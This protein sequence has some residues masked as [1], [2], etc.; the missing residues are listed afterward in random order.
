MLD[1]KTE[2]LLVVAEKLNFTKAAIELNLTQPAVSNHISKLEESLGVSLF[3]RGKTG[4]KLT[5]DGEIVVK[6]AKR[7]KALYLKLQNEV[8]NSE[9]NLTNLRVGITHTSES[10]MT[11][12]ALAKYTQKNSHLTI[13]I[14]TDTIKNLYELLSNYEI[15]I[16]IVDGKVNEPSFHFLMIDTDYLLCVV[17]NTNH[18][19]KQTA[20]SLND[21]R[22]EKM[23]LRLPSSATRV[24]FEATLNS[25]NDSIDNYNIALEVD[26]IATI[27]DLV[28][29][30]LGVSILPK[31]A[32]LNEIK[33]GKLVA[34]AIENLS[35][36]RETMIV[37]NQDFTHF[38]ILQEITRTYQETIKN[39]H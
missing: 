27:K 7:M 19:A 26:N 35:M 28:R 16:A 18:L 5:N 10:N 9:K 31:S 6:Y 33:K 39:M 24:L 3:I 21:L 1:I 22:K 36:L 4:L 23:I 8:V 12:E 37:Y 2:T 20:V 32:C 34:I 14:I 15:D 11:I 29:K 13:T 38:E 17:S 25:I 30:D